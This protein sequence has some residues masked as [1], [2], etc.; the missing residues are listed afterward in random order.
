MKDYAE[1]C[2]VKYSTFKAMLN[3]EKMLREAIKEKGYEWVFY[4]FLHLSVYI[5]I[6]HT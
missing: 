2:N 4:Y 3:H 1:L 6:D 5:L